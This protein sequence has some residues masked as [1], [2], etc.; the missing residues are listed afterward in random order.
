MSLAHLGKKDMIPV[1]Y[2]IIMD[3]P[4]N[5]MDYRPVT[6]MGKFGPVAVPTLI[7]LL[8]NPPSL[9]AQ[10][11]H[12]TIKAIIGILGKIGDKRAIPPL[13]GKVR[14]V[15]Y[16]RKYYYRSQ[17]FKSI[18]SESVGFFYN[19]LSALTAIGKDAVPSLID[20]L[21]YYSSG[22]QR[23]KIIESLGKIDDKRTIAIISKERNHKDQEVRK[24]AEKAMF[25][26]DNL[27]DGK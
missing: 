3:T 16:V 17:P 12:N 5:Y 27:K 20:L 6:A 26:F 24:A 14:E 9:N 23:I 7:R 13:V 22:H 1:L 2:E 18:R 19:A 15:P 25:K 4:S 21:K 8:E 11:Q 10:F